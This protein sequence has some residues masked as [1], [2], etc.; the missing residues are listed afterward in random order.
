MTKYVQHG[1]YGFVFVKLIFE[2]K[3]LTGEIHDSNLNN[4]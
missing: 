4:N 2:K 3:K 1:H